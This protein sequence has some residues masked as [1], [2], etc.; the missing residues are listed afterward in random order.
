MMQRYAAYI[1]LSLLALCTKAQGYVG[2]VDTRVGTAASTIPS[3]SV[4]G[5][6]TEVYGNTLPAVLSHNGMN[7]WT[8]QTRSTEKKGLCPYYY[9]DKKIQGFRNSHW[10]VGGATQDYGSVTIMPVSGELKCL[11]EER[12]STFSH[13]DETA[14]PSY[15]SVELKDYGIKAE[16][17]GLS[18]SGIFRLNYPK[19]RAAWLVITPNSDEGQG[20]IEIDVRKRQIRGYNPVHRI[21][22]GKGKSAGFS[23]YFVIEFLNAIDTFGMYHEHRLFHKRKVISDSKNIGAYIRFRPS[24]GMP[25]MVR[26]GTS[27]TSIEA[28]EANLRKEINHWDFDYV[29]W[30]VTSMWEKRLGQIAIKGSKEQKQ[31]FYGAMYRASF[32]PHEV[33]DADGRYPA[34]ASGKPIMQMENG[35]KYYDDYSMWDTYRALHPLLTILQ[36]DMVADM[37]QSL[38]HKAEQGKWMPIFPCWNSYTSEMIGDHCTATIADAYIKGI[39]NFNIAK[40]YYYMRKNAFET[41][42]TAEYIDGR[43][44]RALGSYLKYGYIPLEDSVNYAY[45]RF[46]QSSRTVE[47]AFD[48]YALAQVA[49]A[50]GKQ[51]DYEQLMKR[52]RYW[53]NVIAPKTGYIAGRH[54]DG[55]FEA[56]NPL[57]FASYITEGTP[58]HYTWYAPHD[59]KQLVK[60]IGGK[61][62]FCNRLDSLFK[63]NH[64]WHGNEPCHHIAYL[65]PYGGEPWKTQKWVRSIV[66][67]EYRN[68]PGG[69]S[70]NDDAGQMSAWYIFSALGFY[71]VC[72]SA[73]YYVIGSPLFDE[74]TIRL[75]SGKYFTIKTLNNSPKNMYIQYMTLNGIEYK[76]P[77]LRHSDIVNGGTLVILMG[78]RPNKKAIKTNF[79]IN[80]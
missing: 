6:K 77:F 46:E 63:Y 51:S 33:S 55:R 74:A 41:A 75:T 13:A 38:V 59:M 79:T 54:A 65:Y 70:G 22:Q 1:L 56:G 25:V 40:A 20:F 42:P 57:K 44:R 5:K 11:D 73:P 2:Y 28:A 31:M 67:K 68:E 72:P 26:V 36:P 3:A 37:M 17:T 61:S 9:Q 43:G 64:Y 32:L 14:T 80:E 58:C 53:Q 23:G 60:A 71:P 62:K 8:P 34:F 27:F 4:F 29:R 66:E 39:R 19:G 7:F 48:D 18:H 12:A 30:E 76:E 47:Y 69:L 50:L 15:Y 35:R 16:M 24:G 45:H 10:I 52:S 21:Y 49:R 78:S